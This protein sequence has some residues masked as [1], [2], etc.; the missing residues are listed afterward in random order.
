MIGSSVPR[1]A[2]RWRTPIEAGA[3]SRAANVPPHTF[4]KTTGNHLT[5]CVQS[6]S[7]GAWGVRWPKPPL[8]FRRRGRTAVSCGGVPSMAPPSRRARVCGQPGGLM[9]AGTPTSSKMGSV[10]STH[11]DLTD[12][13]CLSLVRPIDD[14]DATSGAIPPCSLSQQRTV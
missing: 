6:P 5:R 8:R 2:C 9:T 14:H 3:R 7:S 4:P 12:L 11:D 10:F 1:R 13:L